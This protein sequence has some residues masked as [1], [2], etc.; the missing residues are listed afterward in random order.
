M[1]FKALILSTLFVTGVSLGSSDSSMEV[2][3]PLLQSHQIRACDWW[4]S[5]QT[6]SGQAYACSMYPFS[7]NVPDAREVEMALQNAQRR[8]EALEAKVGVLESRLPASE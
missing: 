5:I 3:K 7:I 1:K 2:Q 4:T 6:N 8:I